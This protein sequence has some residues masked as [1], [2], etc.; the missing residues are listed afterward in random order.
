MMAQHTEVVK[1]AHVEIDEMMHKERLPTL[2]DRRS[3]P[4]I[5]CILKEVLR[6]ALL[7]DGLL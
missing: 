5:D 3:L 2:D 7:L 6:C 1:R 4:I